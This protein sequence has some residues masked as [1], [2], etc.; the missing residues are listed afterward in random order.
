V[1]PF[2]PP[3]RTAAIPSGGGGVDTFYE[4]V[5]P[6]EVARPVRGRRFSRPS[7]K[8]EATLTRATIR[9]APRTAL[10]AAAI[11]L[12]VSSCGG[13]GTATTATPTAAAAPY[14]GPLVDGGT[15]VIHL[16][17]EPP[18]LNYMMQPDAWTSRMTNHHVYQMLLRENPYTYV[19]EP[20]LAEK[21]E[22]SADNLTLTFHL[23]KGVKWHDGQPF[24]S[25][26]VLFTFDK[27]LK[28]ET[29][30]LNAVR[31]DL[32]PYVASY[33][34]PDADTFV[35]H[36]T[37]PYAFITVTLCDGV[38]ILPKHVFEKGDFNTH[39]ANRA[40]IGTGPYKFDHWETGKEIVFVKNPDY[41]GTA[42]TTETPPP[43]VTHCKAHIDKLVF[44]FVA[45]RYMAFNLTKAG[46]ID[47]LDRPLPEIVTKE[48]TP[49]LLTK[50]NQ[51]TYYPNAFTQVTMNLN[52]PIFADVRVRKAFAYLWNTD[53]IIK[54]LYFGLAK[55]I[56]GPYWL[57]SKSSH[58]TLKPYPFDPAKAA[59]LFAEAGWADTDKDGVLDKGGKKLEFDFLLSATS[60]TLVK[61]LTY[62]KNDFD[63]A[64]VIMNVTPLDWA[65]MMERTRSGK[66]DMTSFLWI[67]PTPHV[68]Y[69]NLFHS[70]Q[71]GG[72]LN[73]GA[74]RSAKADELLEK[75][76]ST[77]DETERL[78]YEH[79][80]QELFYEDLPVLFTMC[81]RIDSL[82]S[83]RLRNVKPSLKWFYIEDWWMAPS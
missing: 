15:V 69:R 50:F 34:A 72:G 75:I 11:G 67:N 8:R 46:E 47:V 22:V 52:N 55:P 70:S 71:I 21:W 33:E 51:V 12:A 2:R 79:E 66:F 4:R 24:S 41:W 59:A 76:D 64:G 25:A 74:Y 27:I 5:L 60:K 42:C 44:K 39:P 13:G 28:D 78:K 16:E 53:G 3:R 19:P 18:H 36:L 81:A 23:R 65:L 45:D 83:K 56:F 63:K 57:E 20:E 17:A 9:L 80:V 40:P 49:E 29:A 26:D 43:G 7:T 38:V 32:K 58:P 37:K 35:L 48:I 1:Q 31:E 14:T 61:I 77:L 54:D 30:K 68:S 62:V 10:C 6:A 73:Y 82:V